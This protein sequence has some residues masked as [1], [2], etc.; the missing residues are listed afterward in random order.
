MNQSGLR[1]ISSNFVEYIQQLV[2][3][4]SV[5]ELPQVAFV[6]ESN[7]KEGFLGKIK[8]PET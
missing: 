1:T 5:T 2:K 3:S 8:Q 6:W 7:K 4:L